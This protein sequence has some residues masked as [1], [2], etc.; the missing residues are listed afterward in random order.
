MRWRVVLGAWSFRSR[1]GSGTWR[2][3]GGRPGRRGGYVQRRA[4]R[5][6]CQRSNVSGRTG[7]ALQER[8]VATR[9]NAANIRRSDV[10]PRPTSLPAQNG[11][12]V[13]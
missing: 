8:R 3:S 7:N 4:I 2:S 1:T 6:R 12:L 10:E 5:R 11:Q 9:L 13:P